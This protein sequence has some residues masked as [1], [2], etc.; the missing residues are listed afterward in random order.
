MPSLVAE[1]AQAFVPKPIAVHT[2]QDVNCVFYG[3][4][5]G[6]TAQLFTSLRQRAASGL[7]ESNLNPFTG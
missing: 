6:A 3:D 4:A 5:R 2:E 1:V 7:T